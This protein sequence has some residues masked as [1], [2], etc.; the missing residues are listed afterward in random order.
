MRP[1][2]DPNG[3]DGLARMWALV[4]MGAAA[5]D[6]CIEIQLVVLRVAGGVRHDTW[7]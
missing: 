7:S 1:I 4:A 6:A 2:T 3:P 5:R